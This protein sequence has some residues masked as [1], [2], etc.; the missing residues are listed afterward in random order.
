[1]PHG[2][3]IL[4][5]GGP[6][7]GFGRSFLSSALETGWGNNYF[8]QCERIFNDAGFLITGHEHPHR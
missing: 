1:M 8:T 7:D 4:P 2:C 6:V 5:A 3:G